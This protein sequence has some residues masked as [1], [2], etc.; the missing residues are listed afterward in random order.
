MYI[1]L[2]TVSGKPMI[3]VWVVDSAVVKL[4]TSFHRGR[5]QSKKRQENFHCPVDSLEEKLFLCK[6]MV[7]M[8]NV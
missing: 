7:P 3:N 4:P 2:R 6:P 5:N 8:E 1:N